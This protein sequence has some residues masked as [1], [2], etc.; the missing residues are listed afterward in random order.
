MTRTEMAAR[1]TMALEPSVMKRQR[2]IRAT[3][4]LNIFVSSRA[5]QGD[6]L[7]VLLTSSRTKETPEVLVVDLSD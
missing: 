4:T 2:G 6:L 7:P 3:T 5:V 1:L